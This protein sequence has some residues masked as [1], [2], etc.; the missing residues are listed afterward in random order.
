VKPNDRNIV[1]FEGM[2]IGY[3]EALNRLEAAGKVR[4]PR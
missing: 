2:F 3:V 1:T 4:D